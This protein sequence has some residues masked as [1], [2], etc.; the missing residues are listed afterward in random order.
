MPVASS[1]SVREE[2]VASSKSVR[3]EIESASVAVAWLLGPGFR[4]TCPR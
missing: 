1:K 3:E 2:R 4:L